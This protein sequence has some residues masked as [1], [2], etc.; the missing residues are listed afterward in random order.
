M[1]E[2]PPSDDDVA[3]PGSAEAAA[4]NTPARAGMSIP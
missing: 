3:E 1:T 2:V 4:A